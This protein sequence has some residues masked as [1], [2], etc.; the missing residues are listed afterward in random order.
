MDRE[1]VAARFRRLYAYA[2][3]AR[4]TEREARTTSQAAEMALEQI[5]ALAVDVLGPSFEFE[6]DMQRRTDVT[7]ARQSAL[8]PFARA[9]APKPSLVVVRGGAV[10]RPSDRFIDSADDAPKAG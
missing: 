3:A 8:R 2:R 9:E 10:E 4:E 7:P 6:P 1:A 5:E